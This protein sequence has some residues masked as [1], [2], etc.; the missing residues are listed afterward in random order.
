MLKDLIFGFVILVGP[1]HTHGMNTRKSLNNSLKF[2]IAMKHIVGITKYRDCN[3]GLKAEIL[4][5]CDEVIILRF[6]MNKSL[7]GSIAGSFK[8][9]PLNFKQGKKIT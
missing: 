7:L 5:I 4:R 2:D 9:S 1:P 8:I 6:I 3:K